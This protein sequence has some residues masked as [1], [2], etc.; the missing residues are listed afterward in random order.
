MKTFHARLLTLSRPHFWLYELGTFFIGVVIAASTSDAFLAP[1]V[2]IYAVYFLFPANLLIYGI[3]DIYDYE[4]DI[5]NPKKIQYESVLPKKLHAK[6]L[7]AILYTNTPFI[8][9]AVFLPQ[10]ATVALL[11]FVLCATFYSAPPLRAKAR[12][13]YDS[14]LSAGHY[15]ATG[16]FGYY[17][18]GGSGAVWLPVVAGMAW[19]MAMH[20]YSA[21]PD[22]KAD[23]AAKLATIATVLGKTVTIW[24]CLVFYTVAAWIASLYLGGMAVVLYIPYLLMMVLSLYSNETQLFR[25]YTYFPWINGIVGMAI[26][27]TILLQKPWL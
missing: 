21:V 6:V 10:P 26:F 12:P 4:T 13:G 25:L 16:A 7:Q 9:L 18:A 14:L 17:I 11:L 20:A 15:I 19:A 3:N 1:W 8:L 24:L 5:Q 27:F 22:I 23:K 2:L